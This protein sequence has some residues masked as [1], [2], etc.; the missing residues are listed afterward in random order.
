M[1]T[2]DFEEW[3]ERQDIAIEDTLTVEEYQNY[4]KDEL[5]ITGGSL[6]VAARIYETKYNVLPQLGVTPFEI[7]RDILG[8]LFTETRYA[9]QGLR[10]A[11]GRLRAY[12]IAIN[13]ADE[14]AMTY[15]ANW[16]REQLRRL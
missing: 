11:Y 7:H 1:T 16:I 8:E 13:R 6:D 4:L 10:G 12:E 9:I 3:L 2:P 14:R 15:A 5:G